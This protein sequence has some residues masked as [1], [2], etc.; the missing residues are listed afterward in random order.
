MKQTTFSTAKKPKNETKR[1][2][3]SERTSKINVRP[4]WTFFKILPMSAVVCI[5]K[6]LHGNEVVQYLQE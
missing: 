3:E 2:S 1:M 5:L 6:V 4:P